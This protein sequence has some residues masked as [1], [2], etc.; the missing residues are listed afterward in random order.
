[1]P[2]TELFRL[3]RRKSN[4]QT[5]PE[6]S[7]A[8]EQHTL[9]DTLAAIEEL[10]QA[11]RNNPESVEI[12]LALGNLYRS[13][14]EIERAIHIRNS[15]ISR[16]GLDLVLKARSQFELGRDFRR[17]GM[18]DRS[19]Q[20]F[21]EASAVLGRTDEIELELARLAAD[22][23]E[24]ERAA[25]HYRRV[26]RSMSEAHFLARQ[27][28]EHYRLKDVLR[29]DTFLAQALEVFPASPE[30]WLASVVQA[31]VSGSIA[32]L[33]ET[34][35]NACANIAAPQRFLLLEGLLEALR[36]ARGETGNGMEEPK[37]LAP[38]RIN[39]L[40]QASVQVLQ[41]FPPDALLCFY[42]ARLHLFEADLDSAKHWLEK[43]LVLNPDF[44]LARLEL[45]T[46]VLSN[47]EMTP[48]LRD[49]LAYFISHAR[50]SKRFVCQSCGFRWDKTF[51]VCPRCRSWHSILFRQEFS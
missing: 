47:Q 22:S 30:A 15:L 20:A 42:C 35:R 5:A 34:L 8:G 6:T 12:Y 14:G 19:R 2:W 24:F 4:N 31:T 45:V 33:R 36:A 43:A 46:L 39:E 3:G 48:F 16:P 17:G 32:A 44:W 23:G 1:M 27:A 38:A 28:G 13:Q 51:F 11:V 29:G 37:V 7:G 41:S 40:V 21:E 26:G 18:L 25:G 9:Q 50:K 49:Q 10:S